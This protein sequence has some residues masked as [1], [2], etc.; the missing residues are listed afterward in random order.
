MKRWT[1]A[2]TYK[3]FLTWKENFE[4]AKRNRA[5]VNKFLHRMVRGGLY[6]CL[7][8]WVTFVSD[9][10]KE[11]RIVERFRARFL[12]HGEKLQGRSNH[13]KFILTRRFAPRHLAEVAKCLATW[14]DFVDGRRRSRKLAKRVFGRMVYGKLWTAFE[15][16]KGAENEEEGE[17]FA[18]V[19]SSSKI[20]IPYLLVASLLVSLK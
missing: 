5:I 7:F 20:F 16:W 19:I 10:K 12:N 4:E 3:V 2:S 13:R 8:A 17:N 6:R 11:R 9:L 14:C 18:I 1:Q 15:R